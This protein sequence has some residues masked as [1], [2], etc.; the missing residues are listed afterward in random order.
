MQ[1]EQRSATQYLAEDEQLIL[2]TV[3]GS[4]LYGLAHQHS[5]YDTYTVFLGGARDK[6]YARQRINGDDDTFAIHFDIFLQHVARGIPQ[7]LESLYSQQAYRAREYTP[8]LQNLYPSLPDT[9]DRYYRTALNFGL[10]EYK[11]P[12][13][14]F[15]KARHALRITYNLQDLMRYGAFNP[16][17]TPDQAEYL[18]TLATAY[19]TPAY[20]LTLRTML[21]DAARGRLRW[22]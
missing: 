10:R 6:K 21:S 19:G 18:T 4:R 13:E 16:T 2:Y 3:H 14:R 1:Q 5:D 12:A 15:K 8:L 7:A 20:E 17:L 9:R 11:T 22:F